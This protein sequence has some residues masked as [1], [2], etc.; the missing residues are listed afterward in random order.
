MKRWMNRALGQYGIF[1]GF[2]G[3][4][5]V[6]SAL[7][8]DFRTTHNLTNI[9]RQ[10]SVIGIMAVGM[11]FVILTAGIDLSVGSILALTGVVCAS[12]E[13]EGWPVVGIV[14]GT[15]LLGACIGAI[16]GVVTTKGKVTPFVVTLGMMSIARGLAH[17]YTG[18]QPISGFGPSFRFIGSGEIF[19]VPVPICIFAFSILAAAAIFRYTTLGRYT[20]AIGGNEEAARLSG[21]RVDCYKT[22]AY[23]ICGL[24]SALAAIVLTS[25]LNAGESIAGMG[26]ELDVIASVVI[27]GTSLMGGRGSVWGTLIGALLIG[28]I[29]NGMNHLLISSYY[30]L[31]VKGTIIVAAVLLDRLREP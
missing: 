2:L 23:A 22:S 5:F 30:Q 9:L 15:L 12:L 16:N 27:G 17:I 13:H 25:R 7:E 11:T 14:A 21:I 19:N 20:Y 31:V 26:Y 18:G 10:T 4:V 28:T 24:T 29:N 8:P 1:L 6:L 3:L